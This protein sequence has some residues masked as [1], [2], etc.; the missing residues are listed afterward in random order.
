MRAQQPPRGSV[1]FA[2]APSPLDRARRRDSRQDNTYE[3]VSKMTF[4]LLRRLTRFCVNR[5]VVS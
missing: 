3:F 2:F 5:D 4:A 1:A